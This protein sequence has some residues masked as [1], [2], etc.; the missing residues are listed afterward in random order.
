MVS[1]SSQAGEG[2]KIAEIKTYPFPFALGEFK[3][4][5]NITTNILSKR[6]KEQIINTDFSN[7]FTRFFKEVTF[8]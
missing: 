6:P 1:C 2:K 4:N 5:I 7:I 3:E 8:I